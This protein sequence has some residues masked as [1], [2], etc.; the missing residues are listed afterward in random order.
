MAFTREQFDANLLQSLNLAKQR[1]AQLMA[2]SQQTLLDPTRL[3]D[4]F[5]RRQ[6]KLEPFGEELPVL[7]ALN[8]PTVIGNGRNGT[9]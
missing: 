4:A 9:S 1:R 6:K 3:N 8:R 5:K 2:G 7:P